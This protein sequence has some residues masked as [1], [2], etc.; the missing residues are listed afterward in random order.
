MPEMRGKERQGQEEEEEGERRR[1]MPETQNR[2]WRVI[3]ERENA[4]K[5]K[6]I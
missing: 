3:E 2:E 5:G 4:R 1:G 6:T